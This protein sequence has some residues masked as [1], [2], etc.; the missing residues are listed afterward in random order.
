MGPFTIFIEVRDK[1]L[2]TY[3]VIVSSPKQF[4]FDRSKVKGQ[5]HRDG[6][7][8]LNV[9]QCLTNSWYMG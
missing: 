1:V 3:G 8:V 2:D 7:C 9:C 4:D 6:N 5:G